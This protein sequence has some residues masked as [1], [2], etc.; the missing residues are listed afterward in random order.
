MSH[1]QT[2]ESKRK[3][4]KTM[5]EKYKKGLIKNGM[6]GKKHPNEIK[7]KISYFAKEMWKNKEIR[8]KILKAITGRKITTEQK[9]KYAL[10]KIGEKNPAWIDGR[11]FEPYGIE[12][13]KKLRLNIRRRYNFTCQECF[14]EEFGEIFDV[15]HIDYNKNNNNPANLICLCRE[16]HMQTNFERNRWEWWFK[17]NEEILNEN[18]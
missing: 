5:K 14:A 1:K 10:S 2:E 11:S 9:L 15:H 12:F 18:K 16:C 17:R 13:N 3:I 8:E 4:S 7:E 6:S